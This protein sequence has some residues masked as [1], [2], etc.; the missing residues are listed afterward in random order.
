M[1]YAQFCFSCEHT[2]LKIANANAHIYVNAC[3]QQSVGVKDAITEAYE[4]R[5]RAFSAPEKVFAYEDS[6]K[7]LL[8]LYYGTIWALLRLCVC[9]C[10]W[11]MSVYVFVCVLPSVCL[12]HCTAFFC[13]YTL[14]HFY[15]FIYMFVYLCIMYHE[16]LKF[17][18]VC[19]RMAC[20]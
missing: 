12:L 14:L 20:I 15:L 1:V 6:A 8:R 3:M 4:N 16:R 5:I 17:L 9:G 13:Y 19:L 2:F 7:G 18:H 11:R 10:V